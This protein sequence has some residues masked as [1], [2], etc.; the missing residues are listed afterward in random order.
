MYLVFPQVQQNLK[1][2]INIFIFV[3]ILYIYKQATQQQFMFTL[4]IR[5]ISK[6]KWNV[7]C[8][9]TFFACKF[10][11]FN[12]LETKSIYK[13]VISVKYLCTV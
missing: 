1:V 11:Y 6:R 4:K 9:Y 7:L 13:I 3:F 10:K 2:I 12:T 8:L 5:P